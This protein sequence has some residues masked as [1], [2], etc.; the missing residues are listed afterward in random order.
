MNYLITGKNY[1]S[2]LFDSL[3]KNF[4]KI[5]D[6]KQLKILN[7]TFNE[8]D[9]LY[10]ASESALDIVLKKS[11]NSQKKKVT[12]ILK[13]K[14]KFRKAIEQ[15]HPNFYFSEISLTDLHNLKI[16]KGKKYIIKP[17]KGFFGTAVRTV[18]S[19]SNLKK[20]QN[21]LA[22][23]I[24]KNAEFFSE[25]VLS[26][27]SF[28]VEEFAEG[29]EYA[30]DM[31]YDSN[32]EPVIM[33]I[34]RH[35]FHENEK[36]FHSIYYTG[37]EFFQE[38]K[39][40]LESLFRQYQKVL[41]VKNYPIHCE[42]KINGNV[43]NPIEFNPLRYGGFG[44]A[45]LTFHAF[46]F[47]PFDYYFHDQYPNWNNIWNNSDHK[48]FAWVLGYNGH[49]LDVNQFDP[50]HKKFKEFIERHFEY[51]ELDHKSNP[52]FAIAYLPFDDIEKVEKFLT[53]EYMDFFD[54]KK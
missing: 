11:K 45:D 51:V 8:N 43:I 22:M 32:F 21:E 36:Y 16:G 50:D 15:F 12:E 37:E 26:K 33:N 31:F 49:D 19:N 29:D 38:I 39:D 40:R 1:T 53:V 14:I 2:K 18:D 5:F 13:N 9:K 30:V 25:A 34:Y 44:L 47:N 48:F 10:V 27:S 7:I 42:F 52:A 17:S 28:I 4:I 23:E 46:G 3:D 54:E 41:K 20:L 35:P 6:E 24:K